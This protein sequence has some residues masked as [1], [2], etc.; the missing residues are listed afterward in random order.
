MRKSVVTID[1]HV[2]SRCSQN[3]PY[4]WGP[5]NFVHELPTTTAEKILKKIKAFRVRRVVFTGGDPL[6]RS[7]LGRLIRL[8][9]ELGLEVAV[10][11]TGDWLNPSFLKR[12]GRFIDLISLPL[13]GSSESRNSK[14]KEKGHF[15]T[16]MRGLKLLSHYPSID[17]KICTPVTR[18]NIGDLENI[19]RLVLRWAQRTR[20][21]VFYNVFQAFPRS[22]FEADWSTLL[23]P[24]R[25]F[26]ALGRG[27][28]RIK[29]LKINLLSNKAL[30]KM[31]VLIFPDG[32]LY[33]PSG[34][35]Y[36]FLGN[37]LDI[38]NLE[39]ILGRSDFA[40]RKHQCHSKGWE[41]LS[42]RHRALEVPALSLQGDT[43]ISRTKVN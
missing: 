27:L 40:V 4:C 41:R 18:I 31:Y 30:D 5:Q 28:N 9:K 38:K 24:D 10:S 36:N 2:T 11:T 37:F 33:V 6:Q 7:D 43:S 29:N 32:G 39:E 17:V 15:Q 3:C 20:N 25:E 13:D 16:V 1:F 12:Y 35:R 21:R 26:Q 19:A 42:S 22:M 14:T 34:P 8:A 23:V